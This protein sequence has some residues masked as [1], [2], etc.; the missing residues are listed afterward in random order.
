MAWSHYA[1]HLIR[2]DLEAPDGGL[3]KLESIPMP[4]AM[5]RATPAITLPAK[6]RGDAAAKAKR[7]GGVIG[8]YLD[9]LFLKDLRRPEQCLIVLPARGATKPRM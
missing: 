9:T 7:L 8:D 2:N 3:K 4:I 1:T 5:K 6:L